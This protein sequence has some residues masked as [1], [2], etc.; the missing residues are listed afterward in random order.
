M[1][2]GNL[3]YES[4]HRSVGS[5]TWKKGDRFTVKVDRTDHTIEWEQLH[6]IRQALLRV[7]MPATLRKA[8]LLPVVHIHC[9][10]KESFT[11]L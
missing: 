11:F 9:G 4:T 6:P 7:A 3:Y 10:S 2:C 8:V 1:G 5:W